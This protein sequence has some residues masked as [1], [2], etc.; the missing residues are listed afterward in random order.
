MTNQRNNHG[1]IQGRAGVE[2][3]KRRLALEP[4]CQDCLAKGIVTEAT[5]PD[6][7]VPLA[8][9]GTDTDDNTRNLC[10]PCHTKRTAEQFGHKHKQQTGLDGWPIS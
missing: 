5:T 9:G 2:L 1:R 7:I 3:R 6:H 4:L 10:E 8:L